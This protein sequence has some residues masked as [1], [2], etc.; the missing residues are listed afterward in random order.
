MAALTDPTTPPS[1]KRIGSRNN[2]KSLNTVVPLS[3]ATA[4]LPSPMQ[5]EHDKYHETKSCQIVN[6][7]DVTRIQ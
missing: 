3:A 1:A 7:S 6:I 4:P 2:T 5:R